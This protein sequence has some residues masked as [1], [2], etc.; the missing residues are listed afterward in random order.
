MI[1]S[2]DFNKNFIAHVNIPFF[3]KG[4]VGYSLLVSLLGVK[5]SKVLDKVMQNKSQ[6]FVCRPFHGEVYTFYCR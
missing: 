6:K 5:A 1:S 2:K 3:Y 4:L